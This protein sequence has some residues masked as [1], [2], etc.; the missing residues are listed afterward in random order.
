[1]ILSSSLWPQINI[2]LK[3]KAQAY[4]P[5]MRK[6]NKAF[7]TRLQSQSSLDNYLNY[8]KFHIHFVKDHAITHPSDFFIYVSFV[9]QQQTDD[10]F[11][12][13]LTKILVEFTYCLEEFRRVEADDSVSHFFKFANCRR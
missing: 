6:Q 10:I 3:I 2:E 9:F 4:P 11:I 8:R 5:L 12:R 7:S 13:G 1:V